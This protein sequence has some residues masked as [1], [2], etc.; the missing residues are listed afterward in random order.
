MSSLPHVIG[1]TA[2]VPSASVGGFRGPGQGVLVPL[3]GRG[4]CGYVSRAR[5]RAAASLEPVA[6]DPGPAE[7]DA[8]H[9]LPVGLTSFVG[10]VDELEKLESLLARHRMVTVIG[11]GGSGKTRLALEAARRL[12]GRFEAGVAWVELG[13]L[14]DPALVASAAARALGVAEHRTLSVLD[15]VTQTVGRRHLL[16]V[17]DNCEHV[18]D[19]AAQLCQ[20]LLTAGEDLRVLAT[21]R[22]ALGVS[23][24]VRFAL[25]PLPVP[26][27]GSDGSRIL[28]SDAVTLFLERAGR[29]DVEFELT[30]DSQEAVATI[31][32]RLDGLPL[33]IELAAAQLDAISLDELVAGLQDRFAVLVGQT[34]GV[35]GRLAS[36]AASVDWSYRLLDDAERRTF[37]HLSVF[38]APFTAAAARAAAGPDAA[39]VVSR[40][41]RRSMLGVP[42]PGVDGQSRYA[43]LETLRS[44]GQER[45]DEDGGD[46]P[47]R[48]AVAAWTLSQAEDM[49]T[50]FRSGATE[51]A[52]ARRM[53]AEADNLHAVLEWALRHDVDLALRLGVA[54]SPWWLLRGR[55]REGRSLLQRAVAV[56]DDQQAEMVAAAENWIARFSRRIPD[57]PSATEPLQHAFELMSP[58]GP[59]PVLVDTLW[60]LSSIPQI[61]GRLDEAAGIARQALDMARS[62]GYPTGEA[63]ACFALAVIAFDGGDHEQGLAW[64]KAANDIDDTTLTGDAQRWAAVFLALALEASGDM[65]QARA[66]RT[67]ALDACRQAGDLNLMNSHL[68]NLA[69]IDIKSRRF[70]D[71]SPHLIE[72]IDDGAQRGDGWALLESFEAAAVWAVSH[73]PDTAAVLLGATRALAD[74]I[75][76]SYQ[77]GF[78]EPDFVVEPT[79]DISR[80]SAPN[81]PTSPNSEAR[82]CPS[83]RPSSSPE[84][85]SS[86]AFPHP[87]TAE[88]RP[89]PSSPSGNGNSWPWSPK[90]SPTSRSPR[91]SSSAYAPSAP[92]STAYATR[93]ATAAEPS[94]PVWLSA[95]N[96]PS[97]SPTRHQ[98]RED[99]CP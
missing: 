21:S 92:T 37:R 80:P 1:R 10:R 13:P 55:W 4:G 93:P 38:P 28:A 41:V 49:A 69:I 51:A 63:Y 43:M 56:A 74:H 6:R 23:G 99:P 29:A 86:P 65:A 98:A 19:A 54:L 68:R 7:E 12:E 32:E 8:R 40:L 2:I 88:H 33:A 90:A 59:S 71:A 16:L 25:G 17:V 81:A 77:G 66:V 27:S 62:I 73:D 64:A 60:Q 96:S 84:P 26:T 11:P 46:Q 83:P 50:G 87:A 45:L 57:Y 61:S 42:R 48:S 82:T 24:E 91:N 44:F 3:L 36:L 79:R 31:V 20:Q 47:V 18:I 97:P 75:G 95:P 52:A 35:T 15:A 5:L 78:H 89:A 76:Y 9:R 67:R 72:A 58:L 22:E 94:S 85:H 70:D 30:P 53:D 39:G 14:D 34:R